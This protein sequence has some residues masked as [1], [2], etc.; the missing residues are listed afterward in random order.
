MKILITGSN[1]FVAKNLKFHLSKNNNLLYEYSRNLGLQKL[2]IFT[3]DC[4]IVYHLASKIKSNKNEEY[5]KNNVELTKN[6]C[7]YLKFN[8]N[9]CPIVY[10][11]TNK[12]ND[13]SIYAQTKKKSEEILLNHS[14]IN[15]SKVYIL[16]LPNIFGKWSKPN[17]NSFLATICHNITRNLKLKKINKLGTV[18]LIYIDDIID[19]L[20]K[21]LRKNISQKKIINVKPRIKITIPKLIKKIQDIWIKHKNGEVINSS[22]EF[23][24]NLYSTIISYLPKNRFFMNKEKHVDPRGYFS[25]LVKSNCS[26]QFSLFTIKAGKSRGQ[27]YHHS[28]HEKFFLISGNAIFIKKNLISGEVIK[29]KLN[30]KKLTEVLSVPG[31]WHEIKNISKKPAYFLLW[32]NE[33]FNAQKHDTYKIEL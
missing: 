26:G 15:K 8:K 32:S 2:K 10:S 24:K 3:K 22:D 6:L 17:H 25:E 31:W 14:R 13:A 4:E 29:F 7:S 30:E 12:I 16:R 1:G 21:F 5:K 20:L 27:H 19:L 11:S 9:K 18:N 28:K 23:D 33:V